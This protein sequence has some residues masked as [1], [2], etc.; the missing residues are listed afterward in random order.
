M[1]SF[2]YFLENKLF[3]SFIFIVLQQISFNF[4]SHL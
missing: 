1:T 3:F 2:A 4:Y